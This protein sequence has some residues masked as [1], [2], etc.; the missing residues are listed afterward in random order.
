MSVDPVEPADESPAKP[1]TGVKP[2]TPVRTIDPTS[3][4]VPL[5]PPPTFTP[6]DSSDS[7][8]VSDADEDAS[9]EDSVAEEDSPAD[10]DYVLA[11]DE[12]TEDVPA[13]DATSEDVAADYKPAHGRSVDGTEPGLD[14]EEDRSDWQRVQA[15]F[16]DDPQAAVS[17]AGAMVEKV[18]GTDTEKLRIAFR[19]YRTLYDKLTHS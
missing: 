11:D 4:P 6:A 3:P 18:I 10:E 16:V 17:A 15:A 8:D 19:E 13:D 5:Q 7:S 12:T 2:Y 1:V 14:Q 9:P